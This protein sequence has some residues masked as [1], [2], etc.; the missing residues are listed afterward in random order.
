MAENATKITTKS[1][2]GQVQ[3]VLQYSNT[4]WK[5]FLIITTEEA[6]GLSTKS[7]WRDVPAQQQQSLINNVKERLRQEEIPQPSDDL[8]KAIQWRMPQV[9]KAHKAKSAGLADSDAG[10]SKESANVTSPPRTQEMFD[11]V[12]NI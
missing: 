12:R 3:E 5:R 10:T 7:S 1:P 11:P 6:P 9:F 8:E 2:A 4:Q